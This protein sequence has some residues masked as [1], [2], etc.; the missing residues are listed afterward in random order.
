MP[1]SRKTPTAIPGEPAYT[2]D[3]AI[4][5]PEYDGAVAGYDMVIR[6]K[7]AVPHFITYNLLSIPF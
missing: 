7:K 2:G 1:N 5:P 3:S 4:I 6:I